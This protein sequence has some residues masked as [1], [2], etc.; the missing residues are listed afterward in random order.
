MKIKIV[1]FSVVLFIS[2]LFYPG[3]SL[4]E[5]SGTKVILIESIMVNSTM[6]AEPGQMVYCL[7]TDTS[8]YPITVTIEVNDKK[9][10][11]IDEDNIIPFDPLFSASKIY[12]YLIDSYKHSE[13]TPDYAKQVEHFYYLSKNMC[14]LFPE[15]PLYHDLYW[16]YYKYKTAYVA[17]TTDDDKMIPNDM[18][19]IDFLTVNIMMLSNG[20]KSNSIMMFMNM[21]VMPEKRLNR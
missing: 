3:V 4:G 20:K 14:A 18:R 8:T 21:K 10:P 12:I 9:Y 2:T 11:K 19:I 15:H 1:S 6:A 7:D 13:G 16:L 5:P 17:S